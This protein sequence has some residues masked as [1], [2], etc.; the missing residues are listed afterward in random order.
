MVDRCVT[1]WHVYAQRIK[2]HEVAYYQTQRKNGKGEDHMPN[3]IPKLHTEVLTRHLQRSRSFTVKQSLPVVYFYSG[4]QNK[5][6]RS[7]GYDKYAAKNRYDRGATGVW[8]WGRC[9]WNKT[10]KETCLRA[11]ND[12][13]ESAVEVRAGVPV[14]HSFLFR[15]VFCKAFIASIY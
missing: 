6:S 1:N 13:R 9:T 14:F 4:R 7:L 10:W 15:C 8:R 3:K 11:S 12:Q 5:R 2:A